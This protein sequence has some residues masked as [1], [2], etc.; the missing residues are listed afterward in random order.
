MIQ[1]FDGHQEFLRDRELTSRIDCHNASFSFR[2][3]TSKSNCDTIDSLSKKKRMRLDQLF[4]TNHQTF[5]LLSGS[6][7]LPMVA[8]SLFVAILAGVMAFQLA[9][10]ARQE[11][12]PS[13][14]QVYLLSGAFVLGSGVWSMH[15]IGMLAFS[16]CS[17]AKYD[18][19]IT[20]ISML[21]SF[22]ASWIAL[23]LIAKDKTSRLQLIM[24]G[25]L[26]GAGIGIMHYTGMAAVHHSL[27]LRFEPWTF[28]ISI[29]VAVILSITALW[30]RFQLIARHAMSP[31]R[32]DLI[33]GA[34]LGS[35]I[36]GMHY[37]G[38][39]ATRFLANHN[40]RLE[41]ASNTEL[42][43]SIA[44]I[45]TFAI[46]IT[47]GG[48]I[49]LRYRAI[50]QRMVQTESRTRAIVETA[51]DGIITIDSKGVVR[52]FNSAAE[53]IFGWNANEIIE[54]HIRT[55]IPETAGTSN[56]NFLQHFLYDGQQRRSGRGLEVIGLRRNGQ[57][58]PMRLAL[59]ETSVQNEI[60]YVGFIT[61]ISERR[62]ME[63][64]LRE[65]EQQYRSVIGNLPGIAFRRRHDTTWSIVF[66]SD[67][68]ERLTGWSPDEFMSGKKNLLELVHHDDQK[69]VG[70]DVVETLRIQPAYAIE[71]R[72][73][74]RSGR[75]HWVSES[76]S[77]LR[78][79]NGEIEWIDGV[80]ID[81]TDSKRRNAEFEGMVNA[82]N[83]S[84]AVIEFN[85]DGTII[86]AN[87]N[88][89]TIT[90]Y[91]LDELIGHHHARLCSAEEAHSEAYQQ[92]WQT[93]RQGVYTS[94]EFHRFGKNGKEIWIHGSYNPIFNPDGRPYK[95][96]KFASDL[97]ERHAM[98]Q[99]LR[100]AKAKA[101]QA[102]AAKNTF[103][104]NMSHEIRTP[105]NAI[106]GFTDVLLDE[107]VTDTQRR[108][109]T[110]VRNSARSL[111]SLLNDILD[112]AKLEHNAVELE[113]KDFSL[114]EVCMQVH[115]TLRINAQAKSL[116]L[117]LDYPESVPDFFVGDALRIQQ[118]LLNLVGNAIKFT[119]QGEVVLRVRRLADKLHL[120]VQ[121]TGIGIAP[122][123]VS[124]IFDPFAQADASMSRRFGGTG[125]GTTIARQLIEL[126]H[127]R[128]WVESELDVGSQFH[129]E[130]T[131]KEGQALTNIEE[132]S[133]IALPPLRIL[134][135][136]DV[137]QNLELLQVILSRLGHT[138][139]C[140][141]N[142][143][144]AVRC[145]NEGQ[146]DIVLM[147]V[148]MPV[149]NGLEAT[150]LIRQIEEREAIKTTPIIAL[151][152]SVL[153]ADVKAALAAG[154]NGFSHKPVDLLQLS[155]EIAR[156]LNLQIDV[157]T[158]TTQK[159][160]SQTYVRGSVIDWGLGQHLWGSEL[161]HRTAIRQ[162]LSDFGDA[163][164]R[165]RLLQETPSALASEIHKIKGAASNLALS[166]VS[167]VSSNLEQA[168]NHVANDATEQSNLQ[169]RSTGQN[170]DI[171]TLLDRLAD[172]LV[173][174]SE[175]LGPDT[176][177]TN[178]NERL[179]DSMTPSQI[180]DVTHLLA[181]LQ[182]LDDA[183][184]HGELAETVLS[185]LAT[186]LPKSTVK[187]LD[188]T[189][190]AFDFDAARKLV[191][192]L[193]HH[194]RQ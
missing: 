83:R 51:I 68:V 94:G 102:A 48:N 27:D 2:R 34:V 142:G 124:H 3:H 189:I 147:D 103:L 90:G 1:R 6:Y 32:I 45:T 153:E 132:Q 24:S 40:S 66:I 121:D 175:T 148:Q 150:K 47:V 136:D 192:D 98:E 191:A 138:L 72:I 118:I 143:A 146:F 104:A 25:I 58:F 49:F 127:G 4:L 111:L 28:G 35:A 36:S 16:I 187:A 55:L 188:E 52:A 14:R 166:R 105:M 76:A 178:S 59:G 152:A 137:P 158:I 64:A 117:I 131:L 174:V 71:Y 96:I 156:L 112:T 60:V 13:N 133:I 160:A 149:L 177:S 100:E 154:M 190:N 29:I 172:E 128:I 63:I 140:A 165:L 99:D 101:E 106:L 91:R 39:Y 116:P 56:S 108:H 141:R 135:V 54:N 5:A 186:L 145:F 10:M 79:A 84:L 179:D 17:T 65:S 95:I 144:E 139:T 126:M 61:D 44:S 69:M 120:T 73:I 169:D 176:Q 182:T 114:R 122:D 155:K 18:Y 164:P 8:V 184:A 173:N 74:D 70:T 185:D 168:L 157:Q 86:H 134:A 75:E 93:L 193:Q 31:A 82:F 171:A 162:F 163:V 53:T 87:A 125:L 37:T 42:A 30:L 46:L 170:A 38:M 89:L 107:V 33:S 43:I 129:I 15:F 20:V 67:A 110:T 11:K 81:I 92:F 88:F 57:Q 80:I 77:S 97:T 115:A 180:I 7:D 109:L 183:L 21:P 130:L 62:Q 159:L 78:D 23:L 12:R 50:Y 22:V 194:Y 19:L 161:R 85:L 9:G 181:L 167:N 26:V 41:P 113:D 123:R 151:S 119:Q